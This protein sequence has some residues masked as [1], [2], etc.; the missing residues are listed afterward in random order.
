LLVVL[1]FTIVSGIGIFGL[2]STA[3]LVTTNVNGQYFNIY[4]FIVQHLPDRKEDN[5][6]AHAINSATATGIDG[7]NTSNKV[8]MIGRHYVRAFYWI[9]KYV[10][11]KDFYFIDPH[12]NNTIKTQNI[13]FVLDNPMSTSI[14]RRNE[15]KDVDPGYLWQYLEDNYGTISYRNRIKIFYDITNEIARYRVNTLHQDFRY[16]YTSMTVTPGI[17]RIEI[18]ANY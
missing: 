17:S 11:H 12:F 3:L 10:F 15:L 18:R 16:S 8:T 4:S 6:S 9:P 2:V 7:T 13:L 1:P 14:N 5:N